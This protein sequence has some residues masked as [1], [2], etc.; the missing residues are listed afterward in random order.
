MDSCCPTRLL[1]LVVDLD[2]TLLKVDTLYE[3]FASGL[4]TRPW[5]AIGAL[6]ALSGGKAAFKRRLSGLANVD[7]EHLPVREELF[8]YLV[9]QAAMGRELHLVSA[10][11]QTIVSRVAERFQIFNSATG[12]EPGLNLKGI[13][14]AA[15]L[16]ARF[17]EG[18]V[19]AGDSA[20]DLPVWKAARAAILVAP[21]MSVR[22]AVVDAGIPVE[23]SF[24][25]RPAPRTAWLR[26]LRPHQ[27]AKNLIVLVPLALGWRDVTL[28]SLLT[29]LIVMGLLCV[30]ASLTYVVNDLA[31]LT[32]DRRHWSKR[33]RPFASGAIPV[34]DGLLAVGVLLPIACAAIL[35]V[36][37]LAGVCV[38]FYVAVTLGYSFGWKRIPLFDTFIIALLFTTRILIG[39]AAAQLAPSAWLLTFSM[40]FFFSL[41][42]AKRHTEILRAAEHDMKKLE[43]RGYQAGDESLTLAF[44][45]AAGMASIVIVVIYLVEEVFARQVYN[46]PAWLWVAPI[47]IFLFICRIWGLSHRGRMTDDPVAFALRDRVCLGLGVCVAVAIVLA[48]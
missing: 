23:C 13:N 8:G 2:D 29:T 5:A 27:W 40:F 12:T 42:M 35:L 34:R 44:G 4:L 22:A 39:I 9:E 48:L 31:D 37:P 15:H 7:V 14:K 41:A 47:A 36:A 38:L 11:D 20:A 16:A 45:T 32:A 30:V 46:T 19:Y 24:D 17:P 6:L 1:P 3:Q 25:D 26:A 10:A 33:R 28:T 43:G 18:F 21:A